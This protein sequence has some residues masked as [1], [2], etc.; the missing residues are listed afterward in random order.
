MASTSGIVATTS[1]MATPVATIDFSHLM[2]SS[3]SNSVSGVQSTSTSSGPQQL[4][5]EPQVQN[6]NQQ[7]QQ[8][9]QVIIPISLKT[10][11][12]IC[13]QMVVA[14]SVQVIIESISSQS[15]PKK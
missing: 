9:Q 8:Q 7:Q 11:C 5:Q 6:L 3:G 1:A 13:G 4:K 15:K 10:N 2:G 14:S 12:Q